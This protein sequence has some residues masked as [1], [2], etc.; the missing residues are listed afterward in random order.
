[1]PKNCPICGGKAEFISEIKTV[2]PPGLSVKPEKGTLL[3]IGVYLCPRCALLIYDR[4]IPKEYWEKY[5]LLRFST[6][7]KTLRLSVDLL[8]YLD[9]KPKKVLGIGEF[10]NSF[11]KGIKKHFNPDLL[12][13]VDPSYS[14]E[15]TDSG[16]ILIK[17]LFPT[18]KLEEL[19]EKFDLIVFRNVIEYVENL[20]DFVE[21]V[22]HYLT[23]NGYILV[24][25]PNWVIGYQKYP[26]YFSADRLWDFSK[27]SALRLL[28]NYFSPVLELESDYYTGIYKKEPYTVDFKFEF[29]L[30]G[31]KGLINK[32][33]KEVLKVL[34][35]AISFYKKVVIWGAGRSISD[36]VWEL[37]EKGVSEDSLIVLDC[38]PRK[39]NLFVVGT[40]SVM[41]R[42][43]H[44][45]KDNEGLRKYPI[46][47]NSYAFEEIR[48][49]AESW[50][51]KILEV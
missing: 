9:L 49:I 3:N 40:D 48:Q 42:N 1:M 2:F 36:L 12:V 15:G 37:K 13:G 16:I 10:D 20:T 30:E 17:D 35:K 25:F 38:D 29:P 43:C 39:E 27:Y 5:N 11:L 47:I 8:R 32:R 7:K 46:Y 28:K 33:R 51:Y 22:N 18:K 24:E 50:G 34:L 19:N 41:V 14:A 6:N 26:F 4:R 31:A 21:K 23:E 45:L 44:F